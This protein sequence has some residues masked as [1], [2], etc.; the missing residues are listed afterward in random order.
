MGFQISGTTVLDSSGIQ[1]NANSFRTLDGNS[2]LGSGNIT[3][4]GPADALEYGNV[5]G[6]TWASILKPSN[7]NSVTTVD[8]SYTL[9]AGAT[10]TGSHLGCGVQYDTFEARQGLYEAASTTLWV[11]GSRT[12]IPSSY[13]TTTGTGYS[14]TWRNMLTER[15]ARYQSLFVRI[16]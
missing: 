15:Q 6:Y 2:I 1:N 5:G 12:G 11:G 10:I 4:S 8:T 16:S 7:S 9:S 3:D 14:G 13:S